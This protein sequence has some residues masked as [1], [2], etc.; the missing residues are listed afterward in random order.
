M[1]SDAGARFS[2]ERAYEIVYT[3]EVPAILL[4]SY[5]VGS[6]RCVFQQEYT[7]VSAT[8][9]EMSFLRNGGFEN[10]SNERDIRGAAGAVTDLLP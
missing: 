1:R 2:S 9:V 7:R 6:D 4:L 10:I 8:P 5:Y 3:H